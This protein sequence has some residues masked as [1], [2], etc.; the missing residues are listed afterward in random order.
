MNKKSWI[1]AIVAVIIL[2]LGVLGTNLSQQTSMNGW[3]T[4]NSNPLTSVQNTIESGDV[5]RQIAVLNVDGTIMD[6]SGASSFSEG[7][8]YQGILDAVEA[9]KGDETVKALSLIHI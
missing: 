5:N 2:V 1:I 9:I 7:M 6:N 3:M 4:S 8:D